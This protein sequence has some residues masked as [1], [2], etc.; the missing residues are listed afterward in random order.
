MLLTYMDVWN[1]FLDHPSFSLSAKKPWHQ[2]S[3]RSASQRLNLYNSVTNISNLLVISERVEAKDFGSHNKGQFRCW[4]LIQFF[5]EKKNKNLLLFR[6]IVLEFIL[7]TSRR[8]NIM[9]DIISIVNKY[10][11]KLVG[12]LQL[13][14]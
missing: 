1:S 4:F 11:V 8:T 3:M 2:R 14:W 13:S 12:T 5:R 9:M 10:V 7:Q 6:W